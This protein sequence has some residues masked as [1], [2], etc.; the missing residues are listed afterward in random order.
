MRLDDL[1]NL[2]NQLQDN[3]KLKSNWAGYLCILASGFI[4]KS[5]IELYSSY[6]SERSAPHVASYVDSRI[7]TFSNPNMEK[8]ITLASEFNG[9]WGMD[10]RAQTLGQI[11]N[12]I[13]SI[14][15]NRNKLAHGENTSV[16]FVNIKDWYADAKRLV[17]II[18]N[19]CE[20][21]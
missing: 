1:F 10:L 17:S 6:A 21:G 20:I 13:D 18:E 3:V 8:L 9:Q 2:Y 5:V 7:N 15:A 11:K 14:C 4:E 19:Q 12:S 16:S